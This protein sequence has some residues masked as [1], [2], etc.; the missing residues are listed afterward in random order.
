MAKRVMISSRDKA[1]ELVN[2]FIEHT[3]EWDE[4]D[5]YVNDIYK[6]KQCAFIAVE[7]IIQ[8]WEVIDTYIADFGGKLNQS[9]KYWQ[10]VKQEIENL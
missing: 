6:A 4:L 10:E 1:K 5:G 9:L 7:E 3:Q 2:K 8:Q